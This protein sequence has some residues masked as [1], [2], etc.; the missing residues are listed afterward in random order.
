M[1][2]ADDLRRDIEQQVFSFFE[3]GA[4]YEKLRLPHRRG[5]LFVGQP[6][7][8]KTLML[9][10]LIRQCHRRY[11]PHFVMLKICCNTNESDVESLFYFASNRAPALVILEDMDS[12]ATESRISR[13]S[14][15]GQ[16]D[17]LA[18]R[19]GL[20]VIGTTNN[21]REIDPALVHRPS[22]FDRV[23]RF[24][25]PDRKLRR[26]YLDS[27]F[28]GFDEES[29]GTLA[30]RTAGWRFAYLSELR[31]TAGIMTISRNEDRLTK[32]TVF[33]ALDLLAAQFR[34][35]K[36]GHS[37]EPEPEAVGFASVEA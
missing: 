5:F 22:R 27:V 31:T 34:S 29:L 16:L 1:L 21:P 9:R 18:R 3:G 36:T 37:V 4:A 20:L 24:P 2:F 30:V 35:G 6:G 23:W 7:T 25:L 10:H 11:K 33:E 28:E 19:D 32:E 8:G 17:G 15:L 12:L 26:A 14:F 13:S